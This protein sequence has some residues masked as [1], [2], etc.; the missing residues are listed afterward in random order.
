MQYFIKRGEEEFGPYSLVDLQR[1]LQ[2]GNLVESDLARSEASEDWVP[3]PEIIGDAGILERQTSE[4]AQPATPAVALAELPPN[5]HWAIV[6]VLA[7]FTCGLFGVAWLIIQAFWVRRMDPESKAVPLVFTM[8]GLYV[9]NFVVQFG[10]GIL[11]G[12]IGEQQDEAAGIAIIVVYGLSTVVGLIVFVVYLFT[13]YMM[14]YSME[15]YFVNT[16]R[17][18]SG[19]GEVITYIGIFFF[20]YIIFQYF[21]NKVATHRAA[22][23]A[24]PAAY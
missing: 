21:V 18:S 22:G 16:E 9:V 7:I 1:Y 13:I 8:V 4:A 20:S 15:Q 3:L 19:I 12:V 5:L 2:S 23:A 14:R 11:A 24:R 6:L 17:M 10:G